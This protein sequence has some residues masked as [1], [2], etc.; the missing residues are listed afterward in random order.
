MSPSFSTEKR[1]RSPEGWL[2]FLVLSFTEPMTLYE[3]TFLPINSVPVE[4]MHKVHLHTVNCI[5]LGL[6]TQAQPFCFGVGMS[7]LY[8]HISIGHIIS[9]VRRNCVAWPVFFSIHRQMKEDHD[10]I[11]K[12]D[13][14]TFRGSYQRQAPFIS[15]H[16]YRQIGLPVPCIGDTYLLKILLDH[17]YLVWVSLTQFYSLSIFQPT[18]HDQCIHKTRSRIVSP[19][20]DMFSVLPVLCNDQI[21]L[22]NMIQVRGGIGLLCLQAN[23]LYYTGNKTLWKFTVIIKHSN[24]MNSKADIGFDLFFFIYSESFHHFPAGDFIQKQITRKQN[25]IFSVIFCYMTMTP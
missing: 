17:T 2:W 24:C 14:V 4:A 12:H 23:L 15:A 20:S 1:Y 13:Q 9:G 19:Y 21:K 6:I 11:S 10:V 3:R 18:I 25:T 8:S 5:W 22:D 16:I 7:L